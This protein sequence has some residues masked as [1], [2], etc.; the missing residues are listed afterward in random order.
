M[1][2]L[3]KYYEREDED[4]SKIVCLNSTN[5]LNYCNQNYLPELPLLSPRMKNSE[6]LDKFDSLLSHLSPEEKK[7]VMNTLRQFKQVTS[8]SLGICSIIQH[9]IRLKPDALPIKQAL[10]RLSLEKRRVMQQEVKY[11]LVNALAEHSCSPWS[12]PCLIA[13]K[14]GGQFRLCTD[15]R[16][17]NSVSIPDSYPLSL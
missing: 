14:P 11:L 2:L 15:F 17:V 9:E 6:V 7:D 10:Y 13:P 8:D 1:N 5:H 3:K 4:G 16:K 12:S